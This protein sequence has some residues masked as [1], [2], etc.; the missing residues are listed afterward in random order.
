MNH[1]CHISCTLHR[2]VCWYSVTPGPDRGSIVNMPHI[3]HRKCR[4]GWDLIYNLCWWKT[5]LFYRDWLN[6]IHDHIKLESCIWVLSRLKNEQHTSCILGCIEVSSA[7]LQAVQQ[8]GQG[9]VI[10]G[11]VPAQKHKQRLCAPLPRRHDASLPP[12]QLEALTA[13]PSAPDPSIRPRS[14][15][16]SFR[17]VTTPTCFHVTSAWSAEIWRATNTMDRYSSRRLLWLCD[18]QNTE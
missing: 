14:Q 16:T 13:A 9:R 3:A 2:W 18:K 11:S 6:L 1:C 15:P 10:T 5:F 7:P 12:L 8:G 17:Y 4:P